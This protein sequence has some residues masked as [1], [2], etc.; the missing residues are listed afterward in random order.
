MPVK[1][2]RIERNTPETILM[3]IPSTAF[4]GLDF[5][6]IKR[7]FLDGVYIFVH[8]KLGVPKFQVAV[9]D[10]KNNW[11]WEIQR[12]PLTIETDNGL[13]VETDDGQTILGD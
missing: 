3:T 4:A 10:Y 6:S 1:L 7:E 9:E 2:S 12:L 13:S 8:S 5:D 11:K